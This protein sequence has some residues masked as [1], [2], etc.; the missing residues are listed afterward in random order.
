MLKFLN[1]RPNSDVRRQHKTVEGGSTHSGILSAS[2]EKSSFVYKSEK[3][4]SGEK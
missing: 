4:L 2:I 1:H 3:K